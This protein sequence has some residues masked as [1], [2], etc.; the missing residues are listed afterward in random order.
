H[1]REREDHQPR[2]QHGE[3]AKENAPFFAGPVP[4]I[5]QGGYLCDREP[6]GVPTPWQTSH[7]HPFGPMYVECSYPEAV[8]RAWGNARPA[9]Y[10]PRELDTVPVW[11]R[12][13]RL[14]E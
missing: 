9:L 2:Q 5:V 6:R 7:L 4:E 11:I 13:V 14:W 1:E 10:H 8:T 3:L 12:A